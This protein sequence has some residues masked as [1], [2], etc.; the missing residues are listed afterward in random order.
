MR[1]SNRAAAGA[2]AWQAVQHSARPGAPGLGERAAAIPRM[3]VSR[4]RGDYADLSVP[5]LLVYILAV[6]YVAS[7][8]DLVP[9]LFVPV[10]GLADDVG[11]AVW[12]ATGLMGESERFLRWERRDDRVQGHVVG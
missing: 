4:L 9:E 3:L 7:P 12:L 11:V 6:A 1:K 8:I 5:R 2:A 10:L